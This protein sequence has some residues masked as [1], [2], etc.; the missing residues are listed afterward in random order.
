MIPNQQANGKIHE[1]RLLDFLVDTL[2]GAF[3]LSLG[4]NAEIALDDMFKIFVG[5]YAD[6]ISMPTLC[7]CNED[8]PSGTVVLYHLRTKS[9]SDTVALVDNLLF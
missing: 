5:A 6:G 2:T 3:S 7:E 8:A 4:A 9:D 1:D